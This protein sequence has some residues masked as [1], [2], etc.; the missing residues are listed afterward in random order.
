MAAEAIF[1]TAPDA[2]LPIDFFALDLFAPDFFALDFFTADLF[3]VDFLAVDFVAVDFFR[4]AICF[5]RPPLTTY[6]SFEYT[7]RRSEPVKQAGRRRNGCAALEPNVPGV[8]ACVGFVLALALVTAGAR[9]ATPTPT[10]VITA[11][12]IALYSNRGV[13]IA[14]G[15]VSIRVK[16]AQFT[17]TRALYDLATSRLTLSGDVSLTQNGAVTNGKGYV[18]DFT[19]VQGRFVAETSIPQLASTEAT[20]TAQQAELRPGQSILFTNAQVSNGGASTTTATYTYGIPPPNAKDFGYSPVPT[21]AIEWPVILGVAR[22]SYSFARFRYNKYTGG[23]GAGLEEHYARTGRGYA[24]FGQTLDTDGARFDLVA[25]QKMNDTLTQTLTASTVAG[26]KSARYALTRSGRLGYASLSSAQY[27]QTRSDDLYMTDNQHPIGRLGQLREQ[28]DFGHDVHPLDYAGAQDYRVTPG[29]HFDTATARFG[30]STLSASADAGETLYDYGRATISSDL[31]FW[32]TFPAS[33]HLQYTAGAS[34]A[35]NAPPYPS[36]YRTY[37]AGATW[38]A[39][40]AFNLISSLTYAND[41]GQQFGYGR[42]QFSAAFDVRFRRK[43][44]MGIGIGLIVPFGLGNLTNATVF[45][46]RI[47]K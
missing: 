1:F 14:S 40:S 30:P 4:A 8:R 45:N 6:A 21:A 39:S 38:K 29:L 47:F 11:Q 37:T 16:D 20:V 41:Y 44:G 2:F 31:S 9:A 23:P 34:F 17:G 26:S 28:I 24:A 42:P 22:D 18:Y 33:Q 15:G 10:V 46:F 5:T 32:G 19:T 13:L 43:N 7:F 27:N 36:T 35:H 25:F 3:A 12:Q